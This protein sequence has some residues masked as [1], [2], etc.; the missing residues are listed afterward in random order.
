M[1]I[2]DNT[3]WI[4]FYKQY[5][6]RYVECFINKWI[7]HVFIQEEDFI[8]INK[9]A[10]RDLIDDRSFKCHFRYNKCKK[11]NRINKSTENNV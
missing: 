7:H 6:F 8:Q 2:L 4:K 1:Y 9:G 3:H 11:N 5:F 10:W